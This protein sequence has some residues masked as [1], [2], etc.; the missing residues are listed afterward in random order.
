MTTPSSHRLLGYACMR[1]ALIDV[2]KIGP[3][4]AQR[5]ALEALRAT[6]PKV[7]QA[8]EIPNDD[9]GLSINCGRDGT[10]LH[11]SA[12]S[13]NHA[14]IN[15]ENMAAGRDLIGK[16]LLDWCEDRQTQA[17]LIRA[18]NDQFGVGA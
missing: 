16:S 12:S 3:G 6:E 4:E 5:V 1:Q 2:S 14:S 15:V 8:T 10:W 13:G 18:D 11:F 7:E 17:M 9:C